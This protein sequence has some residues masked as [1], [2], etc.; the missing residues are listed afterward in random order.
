M[1]SFKGKTIASWIIQVVL[2]LLFVAASIGKLTGNPAVIEMFQ[3][4]GFPARIHLLIGSLELAGAIGL[5]IPR[6][7]G[8]AAW[9]LI[10][11]M[12]GAATTHLVNGELLQVLRPV[13]FGVLLAAV[14]V[15]Q[16]PWPLRPRVAHAASTS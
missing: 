9:G 5:L 14:V 15:L 11:V 10:G 13:V 7:A 12:I 6:L 1:I 2:A 16:R 4:W 3:Q 8:Y